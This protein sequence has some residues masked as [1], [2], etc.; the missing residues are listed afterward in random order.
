[1]YCT[2]EAGGRQKNQ[3]SRVHDSA[4]CTPMY[5]DHTW[6]R[7]GGVTP[8]MKAKVRVPP[9]PDSYLVPPPSPENFFGAFSK[10]N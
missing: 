7:G 2:G 6:A 10:K 3:P 5:N 1:M 9:L 8:L 4:A